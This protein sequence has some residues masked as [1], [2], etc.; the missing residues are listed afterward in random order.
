MAANNQNK[1]DDEVADKVLAALKTMGAYG[2]G[3]ARP[4]PEV[5][6]L[7]G[8]DTRTL[9]LATLRLNQRNEPV[10]SSCRHPCGIYIAESIDELTRYARQLRS[11]LVGNARRMAVVNRMVRSW[12]AEETVEP[13][14]QR[15]LGFG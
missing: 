6:R 15:R 1:G 10:L 12:V 5:A 7:V 3:R 4:Q 13:G 8:I 2:A 14:G 11:R 9:Q